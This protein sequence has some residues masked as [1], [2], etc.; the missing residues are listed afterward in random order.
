MVHAFTV[1]TV[2]VT[3]GYCSGNY[4]NANVIKDIHTRSNWARDSYNHSRDKKLRLKDVIT[5]LENLIDLDLIC[6]FQTPVYKYRKIKFNLCH[7]N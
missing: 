3:N 7:F 2:Q 4:S 1:L 6:I 5:D